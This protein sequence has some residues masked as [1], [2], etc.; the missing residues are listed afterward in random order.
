ML[1]RALSTIQPPRSVQLADCASRRA[2]L[3][4]VTAAI[5]SSEDY[6][7]T[8]AWASAFA[9]AGFEGV[10][11]LVSHDPAQ[12]LVGI[13]LFQCA[14]VKDWPIVETRPIPEDLVFAAQNHFGITVVPRP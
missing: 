12:R 13:G 14:G 2:V 6:P 1:E 8:R 3:F 11:Y 10:R 5:H 4:G 9:Q 7:R